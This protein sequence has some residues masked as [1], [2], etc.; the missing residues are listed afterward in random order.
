MALLD[1]QRECA[2]LGITESTHDD[3]GRLQTIA[4][5]SRRPFYAKNSKIRHL[6]E[7]LALKTTEI[8]AVMRKILSYDHIKR[9]HETEKTALIT[10]QH[11]L[12]HDLCEKTHRLHELHRLEIVASEAL[13]SAQSGLAE[14]KATIAREVRLF[15]TEL[16][17]RER[18][19]REKAKFQAFYERQVARWKSLASKTSGQSLIPTMTLK[20]RMFSCEEAFRRIGLHGDRVDPNEIVMMCRAH[21]QLRDELQAR[22]ASQTEHLTS[23]K[24]RIEALRIKLQGNRGRTT[25]RLIVEDDNDV[26][27]ALQKQE[28][29]LHKARDQYEFIQQIVHPVKAGIQQIVSQVTSETV[30]VDSVRAIETALERV[31]VELSRY[32][33]D[34]SASSK[35]SLTAEVSSSSLKTATLVHSA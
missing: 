26:L 16:S 33:N 32:I 31:E 27:V 18:W 28:R 7:K 6:E 19:L 5:Y 20:L 17:H 13:N 35:E 23:V 21:E 2:A 11:Q 34:S 8:S 10:V 4:S 29:L 12:T 1:L 3:A 15:E 14:L 30:N 25:R 24:R 9:R 22:Q